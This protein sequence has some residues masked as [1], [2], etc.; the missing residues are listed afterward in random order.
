M[1][2]YRNVDLYLFIP[3]LIYLFLHLFKYL[4]I[5]VLIYLFIHLFKHLFIHACI[6]SCIYLFIFMTLSVL[7]IS[8]VIERLNDFTY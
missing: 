3:V 1:K 4:F 6:Y 7:H 8:T 2:K 5:P